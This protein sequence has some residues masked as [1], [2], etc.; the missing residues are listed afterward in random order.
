MSI[1]IKYAYQTGQV[2]MYRRNYPQDVRQLLG[3]Q[4]LKQSL[5]TAEGPVCIS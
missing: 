5:K 1:R 4:A 3:T 2:W